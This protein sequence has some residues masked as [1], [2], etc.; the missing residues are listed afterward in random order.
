VSKISAVV[1]LILGPVVDKRIISVLVARKPT[2]AIEAVS[3]VL[4]VGHPPLA[5]NVAELLKPLSIN[6][7]RNDSKVNCVLLLV[8]IVAVTY[9]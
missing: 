2:Q 8:C 6:Q 4:T 1:I 7:V 5:G 3:L 9:R